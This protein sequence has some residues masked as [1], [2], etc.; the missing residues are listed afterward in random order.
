MVVY[1][2]LA[3]TLFFVAAYKV[4]RRRYIHTMRAPC[5]EPAPNCP[6]HILFELRVV[7]FVPGCPRNVPTELEA[8]EEVMSCRCIC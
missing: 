4:F 1:S 2:L 8:V 3:T 6:V 5:A 7:P